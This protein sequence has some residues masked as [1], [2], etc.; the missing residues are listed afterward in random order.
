MM[1]TAPSNELKLCA[2]YITSKLR[3]DVSL[4]TYTFNKIANLLLNPFKFKRSHLK[5][6]KRKVTV[7]P[8]EDGG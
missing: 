5:N 7:L 1:R 2:L 3:T 6:I 4:N 8:K